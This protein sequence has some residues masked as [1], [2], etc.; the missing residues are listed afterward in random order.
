MEVHLFDQMIMGAD[1]SREETFE[2]LNYHYRCYS[3]HKERGLI[4]YLIY[5]DDH[6]KQKVKGECEE[7]YQAD[8][9]YKQYGTYNISKLTPAQ[10]EQRLRKKNFPKVGDILL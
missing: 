10:I 6:L 7:C 5:F 3:C 8:L 1:H 4:A 2:F 9:F